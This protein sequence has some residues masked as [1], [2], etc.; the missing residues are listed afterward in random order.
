MYV[1]DDMIAGMSAKYGR[2]HRRS[3]DIETTAEEVARI[4]A[5][6]V[7]GRDHDVT[8]YI[9]KDD[10]VVVIAK[11]SHPPGLYRAPSG[12]LHDGEDFETGMNREV[13]EETGCR[14]K[15]VRFLLQTDVRFRHGEENVYWR[16]FVFLA[17][18]AGGDF[19]FTDHLEI[20]EVRLAAWS[21]FETFG[22]VM[23][24]TNIGGLLYRAAL[25]EAV[26]EVMNH[27]SSHAPKPERQA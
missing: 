20:R 14:I 12:G 4:R 18:F 21:E 9:R 22:R 5:S 7:E 27:I 19:N 26:V 3:F 15:L 17:D 25:H 23:R 24:A 2:P 13:A 16:S 10:Q 6:Q 11:H 8:V 1:T